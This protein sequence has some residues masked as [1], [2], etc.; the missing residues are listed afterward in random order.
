MTRREVMVCYMAA[1]I[2]AGVVT[3]AGTDHAIDYVAEV[4]V[5]MAQAIVAEVEGRREPDQEGE[6]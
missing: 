6:A 4:A 3:Q 1:H 2:A 5:T